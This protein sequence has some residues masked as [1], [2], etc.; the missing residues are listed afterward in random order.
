MPFL[1]NS[2]Y[3]GLAILQ[4]CRPAGVQTDA[5]IIVGYPSK[6]EMTFQSCSTPERVS[7]RF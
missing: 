6:Y 1:R 5:P 3:I 4:I 2:N 7:K